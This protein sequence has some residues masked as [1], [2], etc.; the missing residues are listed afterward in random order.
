MEWLVMYLQQHQVVLLLLIITLG[1][2][3]GKIKIFGFSLESSGILFVAM[4]FGNY[5]FNL[6]TDFQIFGLLLFIYAIG[7][8]AGPT[9]LNIL[10]KH[11]CDYI[12]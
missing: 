8:Q 9:I 10:K 12:L 11:G 5:G 4:F 1:F 6:N 2:L 3:F 7:L